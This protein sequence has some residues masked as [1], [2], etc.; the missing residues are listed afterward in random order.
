MSP[1]VGADRIQALLAEG[2]TADA[3]FQEALRQHATTE[4]P[5]DQARTALLYGEYLR[6]ERRR[7]DAREPLRIALETFERLGA[8]PW[9]ERARRE[10]RST[11]ETARRRD[12][13]TFDRL[14]R[15][16][17]QVS[18]VVGQGATNRE[19]AAQLIIS[20]R[21]VDHHLSSIFGKLGISSRSE[22]IRI[23]AAGD[24]PEPA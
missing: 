9:A 3:H 14:T 2:G 17:L 13:S 5:L 19:A 1:A 4:R 16:E 8:V 18:R 22:L 15:Q 7:V 11:G 23:V 6:R 12:P 24:L 20:P 10:L 21:T